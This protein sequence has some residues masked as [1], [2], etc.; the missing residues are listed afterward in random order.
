MPIMLQSNHALFFDGVSDSVIIPQGN[1]SKLWQEYDKGRDDA[2]Y[3]RRWMMSSVRW[4]DKSNPRPM[5][6]YYYVSDMDL[7][8]SNI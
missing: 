5:V 4:A 1:F 7:F 8:D 6:Q 2:E 3:S